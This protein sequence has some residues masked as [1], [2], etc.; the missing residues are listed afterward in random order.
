MLPVVSSTRMPSARAMRTSGRS[1]IF[2]P[3]CSGLVSLC[4]SSGPSGLEFLYVVDQCFLV[5]ICLLLYARCRLSSFNL[6]VGK[7]SGG[8]LFVTLKSG[9]GSVG[10]TSTRFRASVLLL[11]LH[12]L[13][14][15]VDRSRHVFLLA[16]DKLFDLSVNRTV[17][18]VHIVFAFVI[19]LYVFGRN[20][21]RLVWRL[22][23]ERLRLRTYLLLYLLIACLLLTI[24]SLVDFST[25]ISPAAS[26][27][28]GPAGWEARHA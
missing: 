4:K 11:C 17:V 3:Y 27:T 5:F 2:P 8:F 9:G 24:E 16:G 10:V 6:S 22:K 18:L 13:A 25:L 15:E 12:A 20:D 26:C 21:L 28:F 1:S 14:L 7:R 19:C 23:V